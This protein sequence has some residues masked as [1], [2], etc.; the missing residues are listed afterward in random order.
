LS[1]AL[2]VVTLALVGASSAP[3]LELPRGTPL[4]IR[5]TTRVSSHRSRRGDAVRAV[6]IAPVEVAGLTALPAGEVV[7]G[8]V[9]EVEKRHGRASLRLDFSEL[10]DEDGG[11][12][13]VDT[14]V[15]TIDDSR[16]SVADDGRIVGIKSMRRL[17]SPFIVFLM[18]VAEVHPAVIAAFGAAR[19][20][21]RAANHSA[22]DY[23]PGVEMTLVL[24]EPL[25]IAEPEPTIP[26]PPVDPALS[27][28]VQSLPFRTQSATRNRDTD[29]TNVL[30]VGSRP[31]VE[32][33]F[34][35]AGWTRARSMSMRARFRGL[36]ALVTRR[37]YKPA[38][39]SRQE[40]AGRPPDLV[41][42]KQNNTLAKRHHVR[43]W[44]CPEGPAGETVWVGAATHD[45]AIIFDRRDHAFTH[46]IDPRIDGE[47]QKIVTD[48]Q[49]TGHVAAVSLV[50][51]P[52]APRLDGDAPGT[53]IETDGRVAVV[54]LPPPAPTW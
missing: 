29:V 1:R 36:W 30:I 5:L 48:L 45:V 15:T 6:L 8:T 50:D 16:E 3:A 11:R 39:V 52:E 26:P 22:I 13:P 46:R 49:A 21:L 38:A 32:G 54:V 41:F 51:R 4:S 18:V 33:A 19:L 44:R 20:A 12:L 23:P 34:V 25:E 40:L 2:V 53:P 14:R 28:F 17:P 7:Q 43:I 42:E 35:E 47:R 27:A 31:Q 24:E 10:V 37:G 9:R